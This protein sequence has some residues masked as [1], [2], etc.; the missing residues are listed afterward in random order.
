MSATAGARGYGILAPRCRCDLRQSELG[1]LFLIGAAG[2]LVGDA[3]HVQSGTTVY[4]DDATPF[5]WESAL[6]FPIL[7]GLATASIGELRLRL[8][9]PRPGFD[10]GVGVAAIAA[11]LGIYAITALVHDAPEQPATILIWALA[12]LVAF[13]LDGGR[14]AFVCGA[15]GRDRGPGRGDRDR[16][17]GPRPLRPDRRL[18]LRRRALATGVVLRVRLRRSAADGAARGPAL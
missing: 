14:A 10:P 12:I 8:A 17:A 7:V 9:P 4:L 2:G 5:I 11:V 18:A 1:I 13:W 6:W 15:R 16:G 3:G